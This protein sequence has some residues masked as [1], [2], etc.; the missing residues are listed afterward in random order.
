MKEAAVKMQQVGIQIG[1]LVFSRIKDR[2]ICQISFPSILCCSNLYFIHFFSVHQVDILESVCAKFRHFICVSM[3][4]YD[5]FFLNRKYLY[6]NF[7]LTYTNVCIILCECMCGICVYEYQNT[8]NLR[9]I[10][11]DLINLD[12]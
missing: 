11:A 12:L 4:F 10:I 5:I 6:M 2:Q 3:H 8:L 1:S 7:F 9:C